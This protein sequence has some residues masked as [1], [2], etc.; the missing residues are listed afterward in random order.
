VALAALGDQ[1]FVDH[2]RTHNLA[3][4]ARFVAA[5]EALGNHG[6]SVVPSEANFVLV[7]FEGAVSAKAAHDAL[8]ERGIATRHLPGQG[9]PHAL[10]ITIGTAEQ[11][12]AVVSTLREL[13]EQAR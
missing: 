8:L 1:G 4:R 11:M 10:R 7:L 5:V 12:D 6:L 13:T 3:E 2:S 9:L